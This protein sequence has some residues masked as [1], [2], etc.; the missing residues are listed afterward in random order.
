MYN[1]YIHIFPNGK[2]Y[3][4]QTIQKPQKRWGKNGK[5]YKN[6]DYLF[7]AINKYGWE[8]I[9]HLVYQVDTK[10]EMDYLE[11]YFIS[12]YNTRNKKYGYNIDSGGN[13]NKTH[14]KE[15]KD[16]IKATLQGTNTG[17]DNP[18]WGT[19]RTEEF[20]QKMSSL[21]GLP[22]YQYSLDGEFIAKYQSA[23]DAA[24]AINGCKSSIRRALKRNNNT[25][26]GYK[27]S[28]KIFQSDNTMKF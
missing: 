7:N 22:V 4:G 19:H 14:S 17:E 13:V 6:M 1:I 10:E 20:K 25:Y 16:K 5:G 28:E 21:Y 27:W 11:K 3:V 12:F 8:N 24:K 23:T 9:Q 26:K 15:T 18:M 2:R